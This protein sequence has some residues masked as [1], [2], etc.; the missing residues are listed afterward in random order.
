MLSHISAP[1]TTYL[2]D[3]T[4]PDYLIENVDLTF[5]LGETNTTVT[6]KL[7]AHRNGEHTKPLVL[8]GEQLK[9]IN[10]KLNGK[11]LSNTDYQVDTEQLVIENVP[12]TFDLEVVT[13]INPQANTELSGLYYSHN[14]FCTQCEAEGFRRMTYFLDRPDV[15]A[16]YTTT[17]IA[18]KSRY[19][20]LLSNG[21]LIS[22]QD[23]S[24][25]RH[26]VTWQDP[27]KKPCYLF[28]LVG[29]D[30]DC[31]EDKFITCSGREVKLQIFSD[32]GE[33]EKCSHAMDS[34]KKAMRW[35]EEKYG[36]EYDLDIFMIVAIQAF[37][38]G[39]MENK[40]LNIF[41]A[42]YILAKPDTATD[43]DYEHIMLVV[44]HEYFHNWTGNRVTCRDW[45]QLS[46][47]EGLTVFREHQFTADMTSPLV[48]RI[49]EVKHLRN[50][51]FIEDAGPLAHPVQP[52]AYIEINNFY[53]MTIYEKG[54]EVIRMMKTFS[55]ADKFRKGMDLYFECN[56]GKAVTIQDFVKAMEDANS[57][58][59]TQF[60]LWYQQAGTPEL[61]VDGHY[62]ENKKSFTLTVKQSCPA[63]PN[64]P[65]KKP[66]HIP[67]AMALLDADGKVITNTKKVLELKSE[68]EV[69]EF[70]NIASKPV[71]SLL[72]DFSAPVKLKTKFT[73]AELQF[74]LMHDDDGFNRWDAGQQLAARVILGNKD[75]S[76]V[77]VDAFRHLLNANI[78][79]NAFL[80]ELLTLPG[81]IYLGEQMSVIDVDGIHQARQ[82][83]RKE[84][85]QQLQ[86]DFLNIYRKYDGVAYANDAQ[87]IANRRLKNLCLNYLMLLDNPEI[88]SL[89]LQQFKQADNMTDVINALN[90]LVNREGVEREQALSDFYQKWQHDKL[91]IDKWFAIQ[92][93]SDLPNT[94]QQVKQLLQH[95]AFD[96]KNPNT[97]R[98]VIGSFCQNL[99]QFHAIG[100]SGYE[101]LA[102]QILVLDKL[103]PQ[104][105][106]R[107]LTPMTQWHR[108]DQKRQILQKAQLERILK[109][110]N[111]SKD[112]Y[113]ITAKS[114]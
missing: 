85:T 25:N 87:S 100:G 9:L 84:L 99:F 20:V 69:F 5:E 73:D 55:G 96:I 107:L 17:I 106:A 30:L 82:A 33:K 93:A 36:R 24:N 66:F 29:G 81:E 11:N 57:Q 91:V 68:I 92:A 10:L 78:S 74:L 108:Y 72:R 19:P 77:M 111:I 35:D 51:Q 40:G 114:L 104:I 50:F 89:C 12:A 70:E 13:Q 37:N 34:V 43:T 97:V 110:P 75:S 88:T 49:D 38:M 26:R 6:A 47:K 41:N 90:C 105:A 95:P 113:E 76:Q 7:K 44:G 45:F 39:A 14:I 42:K 61:D 52:D 22:Q 63:T 56:D 102:E 2:K 103:N 27:F 60:K 86:Q 67:L 101:F 109:A 65:T 16:R 59:L 31:L 71:P 46:L 53:T 28:A 94:L 4:P 32:K 21:N 83:L 1:K 15:L 54:A 80:A 18:D 3:Y 62:D 58:D 112:V 48:T 98:A 8:N 64:Q 23:L 79:D